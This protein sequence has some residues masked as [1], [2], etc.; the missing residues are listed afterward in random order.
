MHTPIDMQ[1]MESV[2][3]AA[4]VRSAFKKRLINEGEACSMLADLD[5]VLLK[6]PADARNLGLTERL[7]LAHQH[8]NKM[9]AEVTF[10]PGDIIAPPL[11]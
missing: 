11:R 3:L 8:I 1:I 5:N 6:I 4:E 2:N 10:T 7:R 9:R